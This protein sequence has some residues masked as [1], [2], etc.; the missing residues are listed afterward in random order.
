[1]EQSLRY[2]PYQDSTY[3]YPPSRPFRAISNDRYKTVPV[4]RPQTQKDYHEYMGREQSI[5]LALFGNELDPAMHTA[6]AVIMSCMP[7]STLVV[8]DVGKIPELGQRYRIQRP[9][10]MKMNNATI[11]R[12][13]DNIFTQALVQNFILATSTW[14]R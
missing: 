1:M 13:Y 7:N 10:L 4:Y 11:V 14:R 5:V 2:S 3:G 9:T 6:L 12:P 8:V